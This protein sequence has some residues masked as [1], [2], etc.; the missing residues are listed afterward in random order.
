[1]HIVE[2]SGFTYIM[3]L[4]KKMQFQKNINLLCWF[5]SDGV[6]INNEVENKTL[7]LLVVLVQSYGQRKAVPKRT[8][9]TMSS[10]VHCLWTCAV[11]PMSVNI[12]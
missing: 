10:C 11:K 4:L 7:S 12:D 2:D 9:F 3:Q 6:M 1:M 5:Y 8:L